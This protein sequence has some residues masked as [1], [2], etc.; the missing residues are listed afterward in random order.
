MGQTYQPIPSARGYVEEGV[1]SW[2]GDKFHGRPTACGETY[3]MYAYTAAHRILPMQTKVLVTNL[4]N[5]RRVRV[6]V[7]DRGPFVKNRVIDLSLAAARSLD[8][9]GKGTARVLVQAEGSWPEKI[10]GTFYV[11]VGSFAIRSNALALRDKMIDKGYRGTRLQRAIIEGH[12]FWRVQVGSFA[13]LTQANQ[14]LG[15]LAAENPSS[16]VIAD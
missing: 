16:F 6:R 10:P 7:N 1:A 12:T 4:E 9:V 14:A 2:Y 8:M 13:H 11:Q 5:G 15:R 3:D